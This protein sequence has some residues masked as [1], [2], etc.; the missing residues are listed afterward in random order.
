[1]ARYRVVERSG[2]GSMGVVYK[3]EDSELGRFVRSRFFLKT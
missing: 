1:M 3:A 2:S